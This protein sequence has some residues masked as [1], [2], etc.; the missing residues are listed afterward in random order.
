MAE[1]LPYFRFTV[2]KWMNGDIQMVSDDAKGNF[3]DICAAYWFEDCSITLAKL[4]Q[5]YSKAT[6]NIDVL[7]EQDIIK[8]NEE[9]DFIEIDF[10]N[11]QYEK[12]GNLHEARVLAGRKGGLSKA[13]AKL[14]QKPSYKD[15]DNDKEKDKD[16]NGENLPDGANNK[17]Q[18]VTEL[19]TLIDGIND[20]WNVMLPEINDKFDY[21][22]DNWKVFVE[23]PIEELEKV[24]IFLESYGG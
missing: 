22:Y 24:K 14:K 1:N 15:K 9:T 21:D 4:K 3:A 8:H 2:S 11:K 7:L 12:L 19:R 5:K 17:E 16:N 20:G 13:K 18:L 23:A 10:L 6:P